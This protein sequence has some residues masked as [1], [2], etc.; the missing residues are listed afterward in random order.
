MC[1]RDRYSHAI[2]DL[3]LTRIARLLADNARRGDLCC[4]I[5]G[6]EFAIVL[7]DTRLADGQEAAE[8]IRLAVFQGPIRVEDA[9]IGVTASLGV[10]EAAANDVDLAAVLARADEALF[11]A[12]SAGR[13]RV[14][15]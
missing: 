12:K 4:R 7:P 8:R 15:S 1:I 9:V 14:S 13:N 10:V 11:R 5:G 2:G 3:V 6:E